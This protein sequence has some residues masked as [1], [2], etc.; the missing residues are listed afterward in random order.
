M[1]AS[2]FT[3]TASSAA[4]TAASTAAGAAMSAAS[5]AAGAARMGYGYATGDE[6]AKQAGK[7]AVNAAYE[8]TLA[9][10]L[11]FERRLFHGLF[12]TQDQK[13]GA[14][15]ALRTGRVVLIGYSHRLHL[16]G[17]SAFAEKRKPTWNHS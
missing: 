11:R 12:A 5:M 9:E 7:E 15:A 6:T 8:M 16:V 3:S 13:E 17:M 10:G 2:N 4:S 1:G 14:C